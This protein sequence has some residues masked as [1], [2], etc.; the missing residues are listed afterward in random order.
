VA[1]P[2]WSLFGSVLVVLA[3][4]V[5]LINPKAGPELKWVWGA[6]G[7]I[8]LIGLIWAVL[9]RRKLE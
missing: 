2:L 5:W 7:G 6:I 9:K 1:P 4:L 8:S 3:S